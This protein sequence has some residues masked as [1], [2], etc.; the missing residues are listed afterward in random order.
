MAPFHVPVQFM[1]DAGRLAYGAALAVPPVLSRLAMLERYY[2]DRSVGLPA[3]WTPAEAHDNAVAN[4]PAT[5]RAVAA[6][7]LVDRLTV[8]DRGGGVLY[9]GADPD[10]FAGQWERG[11][12]RPLSA[13][14]TADARMRLARIGSLRSVPG[15]GTALSDPVVASIRRSLDD[16]A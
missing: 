4:L 7:L 5:V 14:E 15:V 3:R 16:L 10:M 6:S 12:H 13:V 8:I 9:D 2:R 1:L 11:F